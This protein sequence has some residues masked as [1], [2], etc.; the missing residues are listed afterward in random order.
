MSHLTISKTTNLLVSEQNEI[1]SPSE[2]TRRGSFERCKQTSLSHG[3][4]ELTSSS[5]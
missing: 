4:D 3:I 1:Y 2:S 5:I